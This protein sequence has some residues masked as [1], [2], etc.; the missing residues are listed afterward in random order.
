MGMP[1]LAQYAKF[2]G[3]DY[4]LPASKTEA[5]QSNAPSEKK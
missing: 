5:I 2:F 1:P 3:L 4:A